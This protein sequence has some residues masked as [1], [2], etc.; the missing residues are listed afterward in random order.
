MRGEH[1]NWSLP[2]AALVSLLI[3]FPGVGSSDEGVIPKKPEAGPVHSPVEQQKFF[4][5]AE[6][7]YCFELAASEPMVRDPVMNAPEAGVLA[8]FDRQ[9]FFSKLSQ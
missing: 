2:R 7:G 5:L 9:K 6:P 4:R 1:F 8:P 3:F